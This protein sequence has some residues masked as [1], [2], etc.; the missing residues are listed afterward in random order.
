MRAFAIAMPWENNAC[1]AGKSH[2]PVNNPVIGCA[3]AA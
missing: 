2:S 3:N 1:R